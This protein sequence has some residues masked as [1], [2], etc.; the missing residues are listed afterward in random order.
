MS[1]LPVWD[2]LGYYEK[3]C[4]TFWLAQTCPRGPCR[5][6]LTPQVATETGVILKKSSLVTSKRSP[7]VVTQSGYCSNALS[8]SVGVVGCTYNQKSG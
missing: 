5:F 8:A 3:V 7:V 1:L 6:A 2:F 4:R